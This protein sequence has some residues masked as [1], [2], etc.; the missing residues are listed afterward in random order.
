MDKHI[1]TIDNMEISDSMKRDIHSRIDNYKRS[2]LND[3]GELL[4]DC[5]SEDIDP[6]IEHTHKGLNLRITV[7]SEQTAREI[8]AICKYAG[9]NQIQRSKTNV[10]SPII[11]LRF[12]VE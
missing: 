1:E 10:N 5:I 8:E 11:W 4:S 7:R 2:F 12:T 3:I 9:L 6:Y